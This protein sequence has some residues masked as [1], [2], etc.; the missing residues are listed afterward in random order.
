MQQ[1]TFFFFHFPFPF[2]SSFLQLQYLVVLGFVK[3]DDKSTPWDSKSHPSK[4]LVALIQN[5]CDDRNP[6][7]V[8]HSDLVAVITEQLVSVFPQFFCLC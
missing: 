2:D 6:L 7:Y 8:Q 3:F 1:N 5:F 4:D